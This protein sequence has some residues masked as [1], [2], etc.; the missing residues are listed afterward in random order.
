MATGTKIENG[1][2]IVFDTNEPIVTNTFLNTID[3]GAPT[4]KVAALPVKLP[5]QFDVRWSG[6]DDADGSGLAFFDVFVSDNGGPFQLWLNQATA[7]SDKFVGQD[8]HTYR[9]YSVATDNVGHVEQKTVGAEAETTV[10]AGPRWHNSVQS[11]D[12]DGDGVVAPVDVLQIINE[13]NQPVVAL[14]GGLLPV[15]GAK[16]PPPFLDVDGDGFISPI[17]ALIVIN[18]LN[19]RVTQS[20]GGTSSPTNPLVGSSPWLNSPISDLSPQRSIASR[21]DA[22]RS[23]TVPPAVQI[24]GRP[25]SPEPAES[26]L[27]ASR[28]QRTLDDLLTARRDA[29]WECLLHALATD[30]L[31]SRAD[32]AS[33]LL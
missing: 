21:R 27:P 32:T 14:A 17:D 12:V 11:E 15:S 23:A 30:V 8:K 25:M 3:R 13:L 10:T 26:R 18:F 5:A 9:F 7:T 6:S 29:E 19:N 20:E 33:L 1:A 24:E 16:A 22:S 31:E 2:S 4:S 28:S